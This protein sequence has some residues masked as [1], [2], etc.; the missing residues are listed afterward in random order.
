MSKIGISKVKMTIKD[1]EQKG[2]ISKRTLT[3]DNGC[4]NFYTLSYDYVRDLSVV[5]DGG[6]GRYLEDYNIFGLE[7]DDM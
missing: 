1:L 3:V 4:R 5:H 7:K 2:L 6:T